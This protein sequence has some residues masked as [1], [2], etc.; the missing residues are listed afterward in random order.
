MELEK[1]TYTKE[2][3]KQLCSWLMNKC[4]RD[5][6]RYIANE[7]F[8]CEFMQYPFWKRW[9]FGR[10]IMLVHLEKMLNAEY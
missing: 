1:E 6:A 2:E 3:V 8:I 7:K 5:Q 9:L 10:E 4:E